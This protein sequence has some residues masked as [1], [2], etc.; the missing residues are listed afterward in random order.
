MGP[1]MDLD[2]VALRAEHDAVLE[3]VSSRA[4]IGHFAHG[5]VASGVS[6][7]F[8]AASVKLWWDFSEYRP[9]YYLAGLVVASGAAAYA[10]GRLL[11]GRRIFL[12]EAV[13]VDRLLELRRALHLDVPGAMLPR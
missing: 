3:R 4:S 5:I 7:L 2:A 6:I 8:L 13:E 9:E 12:Q 10:A 1:R 11:V